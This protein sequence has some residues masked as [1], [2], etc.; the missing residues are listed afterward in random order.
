[1]R[2]KLPPTVCTLILG[3]MLAGNVF[4]ATTGTT[5]YIAANGSDSNSGTSKTSSWVHAPG[6]KNCANTCAATTPKAGDQFIFRGGDT[7]HFGNSSAT[8]AVGTYQSYGYWTWSW[9][10]SGSNPIYVGVDQTWYSGSAWTRPLMTGDNPLSTSVVSSCAY[11]ESG[12]NFIII[13][14]VSNV[15]I[16][17]LEWTGKCWSVSGYSSNAGSTIYNYQGLNNTFSNNYFHGWTLTPVAY[18]DNDMIRGNDATNYVTNTVIAYN[19]FDGS[20]SSQGTTAAACKYAVNG[21][22]CTS[23]MALELDAYIVYGNVFRYLSNGWIANNTHI[24]HDNLFEYLYNTVTGCNPTCGSS[25]NDGPHPN[26]FN[27]DGNVAG[28]GIYFYNNMV[29]HTFQN[30]GVWFNV[31]STLYFFNNVIFDSGSIGPQ[32]CIMINNN[33]ASAATAYFYN[34]TIDAPCS[35]RFDEANGPAP[36][37]NGTVYFQNNHLIGFA[38]LAGLYYCDTGATCKF[39]DNGNEVIQTEAAA[40]A[41]GYVPGNNYAPTASANATVGAGTNLTGNCST[42][43]SDNEYCSG[44]SGSVQEANGNGG[45]ITNFPAVSMNTR[46]PNTSNNWDVGAYEYG[47]LNPPT[48]LTAVVQ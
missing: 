36:A 38:N 20:D 41:Q 4:A 37:W 31:P 19:V 10:G 40:N 47:S 33:T 12:Q 24:V 7:W 2:R 39:T 13:Y 16:D 46:P 8:P 6:M 27:T 25:P 30:V 44:T 17:N 26:I 11:D 9:G 28:N 21:A 15:T 1:M 18:D 34:N 3:L 5:Y 23:G 14:A 43:S 35:A 48:G 32:N 29:R 22:P 42:F 45:E